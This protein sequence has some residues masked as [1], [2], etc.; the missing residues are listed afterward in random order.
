MSYPSPGCR[1]GFEVESHRMTSNTPAPLPL[2]DGEEA[3]SQ[4]RAAMERGRASAG[5]L[6]NMYRGMAHAP[7]LLDTYLDGST[8]FRTESGFSTTEQEVVF[9]SISRGNNCTYCVAGHSALATRRGVDSQVIEALRE[10]R[11]LDDPRYEVLRTITLE[12]MAGQGHLNPGLLEQFISAGYRTDQV[13]YIILAI[14]LK[15]LS[16]STN[17]YLHTPLDESFSR[18]IWHGENASRV[19]LDQ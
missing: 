4:S 11:P 14:G 6:I 3:S 18:H 2:L 7:G 19:T 16:N 9:I 13:L 5:T 15:V 17:H 10:G 8:R 1:R 12:T